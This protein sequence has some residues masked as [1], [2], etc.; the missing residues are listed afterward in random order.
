MSS[1]LGCKQSKKED[2]FFTKSQILGLSSDSIVHWHNENVEYFRLK[3]GNT[4]Q[5]IISLTQTVIP[6]LEGINEVE[7][8]IGL[9]DL[10]YCT[11]ARIKL[12]KAQEKIVEVGSNNMLDY[13]TI[14]YLKPDL[15]IVNSFTPGDQ[16]RKLRKLN[17]P[18]L[19]FDEHLEFHPLAKLDWMNLIGL[20]LKQETKAK[21]Y[22]DSVSVAYDNLI[23]TAS[24]TK[25]T[26]FAGQYYN[27][28]WFVPGGNSHFANMVRDAGGNYLISSGNTNSI[29][30]GKEEV[31][32]LS[33]RIDIWRVIVYNP[34][35]VD[36]G[37]FKKMSLEYDYLSNRVDKIIACN[38]A[39][40]PLYERG[41]IEPHY[42]LS[43]LVSH[44]HEE[45]DKTNYYYYRL[46]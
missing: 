10:E 13:E 41:V 30:L 25:P 15:V 39:N 29:K 45:D 38:T 17:I 1:L 23:R 36:L 8:L 43:D 2:L 22:V 4:P 6:I 37:S 21:H 3:L 35:P 20:V 19:F 7:K 11:N 24:K 33:D 26:V 44:L 28:T 31:R 27:G 40:S 16:I 14:L 5:R 18:L 42:L 12:L 9:T 32:L 46:K 34:E